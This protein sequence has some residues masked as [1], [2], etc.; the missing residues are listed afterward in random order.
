[1]KRDAGGSEG[2]ATVVVALSVVGMGVSWA[3]VMLERL[4]GAGDA[5]VLICV[6]DGLD[7]IS[8]GFVISLQCRSVVRWACSM[9]G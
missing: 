5:V 6:V 9:P 8:L 1:M 2:T 7:I 3:E 4:I